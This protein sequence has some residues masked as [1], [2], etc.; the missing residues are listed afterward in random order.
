MGGH[1]W[2]YEE[3]NRLAEI[4]GAKVDIHD[5]KH[6]HISYKG[7]IVENHR[8]LTT[9]RGSKEKKSFEM[10]LQNLLE[11]RNSAQFEA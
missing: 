10:Y 2:A 3:G 7:L 8:L 5:Y 11:I 6:S 9:A 1:E 4:L